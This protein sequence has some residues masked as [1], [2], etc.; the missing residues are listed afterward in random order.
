MT[1]P[2]LDKCL[3]QFFDQFRRAVA[4]HLVPDVTATVGEQVNLAN[5]TRLGLRKG[6]WPRTPPAFLWRWIR[7]RV[8]IF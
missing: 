5:T 8:R 4:L 2:G 1:D 7:R 6:S 3:N